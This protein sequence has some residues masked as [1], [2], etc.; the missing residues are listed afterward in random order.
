MINLRRH[1]MIK[2]I[3]VG[4]SSKCVYLGREDV[5]KLFK[6]RT[7]VTYFFEFYY[8]ND[9]ISIMTKKEILSELRDL[10]QTRKQTWIKI[11]P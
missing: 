5:E 10:V 11:S 3:S 6:I 2:E 1:V 9:K 7:N 8:N 4:I